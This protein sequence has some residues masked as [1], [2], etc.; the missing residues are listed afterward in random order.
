MRAV[1]DKFDALAKELDAKATEL[2]DAAGHMQEGRQAAKLN[3]DAAR[4]AAHA[5]SLRR[6][7]WATYRRPLAP[8][9]DGT[10][11]V[12]WQAHARRRVFELFAIIYWAQQVRMV[13]VREQARIN[14]QKPAFGGKSDRIGE[15]TA[16]M[17]LWRAI[18]R[19]LFDMRM[20]VFNMGSLRLPS[21]ARGDKC[22]DRADHST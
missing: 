18:G 21:E 14:A 12:V 2:R 17:R 7:G 3:L 13:G 8:K 22:V 5:A 15:R 20:M 19:S 6:C 4:E 10:R 1:A 9:L 16:Q 11:K